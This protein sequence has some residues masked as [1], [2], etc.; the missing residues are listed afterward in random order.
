MRKWTLGAVP[1]LVIVNVNDT[2][3]VVARSG[4]M[5]ALPKSWLL[6][7]RTRLESGGVQPTVKTLVMSKVI[8]MVPVRP[9]EVVHGDPTSVPAGPGSPLAPAGPAG[10]PAPVAPA[11]PDAP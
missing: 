6:G 8:A 5:P 4:T 7:E 3:G 2:Y 11:G 10:P 1:V 9:S